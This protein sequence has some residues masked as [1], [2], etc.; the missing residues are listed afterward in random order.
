MPNYNPYN[1]FYSEKVHPLLSAH[2]KSTDIF[3]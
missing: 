1:G 3:D 2:I